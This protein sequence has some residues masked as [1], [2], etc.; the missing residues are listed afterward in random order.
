M[1]L[2]V[3]NEDRKKL[4]GWLMTAS[5]YTNDNDEINETLQRLYREEEY[6]KN[7]NSPEYF[8]YKENHSES[9]E[10]DGQVFD[11]DYFNKWALE[12]EKERYDHE[13]KAKALIV[14]TD[15]TKAVN[16]VIANNYCL[17]NDKLAYSSDKELDSSVKSLYKMFNMYINYLA[18]DKVYNID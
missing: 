11:K 7:F 14:K 17:D 10:I 12:M 6:Y 5:Y 15:H 3:K 2:V 1:K 16:W 8:D 18:K 4:I 13:E 9:I